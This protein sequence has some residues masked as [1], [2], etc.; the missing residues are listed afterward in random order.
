MFKVKELYVD[1]IYNVYS[2]KEE[3]ENIFFLVYESF[4]W[5]WMNSYDLEPVE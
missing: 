2:V 1:K 4:R 3:N 5:V